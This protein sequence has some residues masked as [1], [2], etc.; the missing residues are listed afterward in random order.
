MLILQGHL[1]VSVGFSLMNMF[2][3]LIKLCCLRY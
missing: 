1:I 3:K 2:T